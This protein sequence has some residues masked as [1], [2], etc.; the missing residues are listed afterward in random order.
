MPVSRAFRDINIT[1][2]KHPVTDDLLI[3]KDFNAIKN[4]VM[5]L[6]LTVPGERFFNPNI[7]SKIYT[8]LFEPMDFITSSSI[9]SEIEYTIRAFEP[10]V[11]LKNVL[12]NEDYDNNAY[13]IEIEYSV[14]GLPEKLDTI[15]LTL[16]RTRA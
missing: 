3:V 12:V 10:R 6:I 13:D 5:S 9:K 8:L 16:E 4:S 7:G 1:F 15:Q 14:I 2:G 11:D